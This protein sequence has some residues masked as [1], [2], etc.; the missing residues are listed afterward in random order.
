MAEAE[1]AL[2][3]KLRV[4]DFACSQTQVL[5]NVS[6][7]DG[8]LGELAARSFSVP[9]SAFPSATVVGFLIALGTAR[10]GEVGGALRIANF[11]ILGYL[12]DNGYM[13]GTLTP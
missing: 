13:T 11:R 7:V 1:V 2:N 6:L 4:K 3:T 12:F 8:T 5:V 10:P 9:D